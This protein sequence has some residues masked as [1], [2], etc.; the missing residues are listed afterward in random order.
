MKFFIIIS[1]LVTFRPLF[2]FASS[3][4]DSN[5]ADEFRSNF[6][7]EFD[8]PIPE[9]TSNDNGYLISN[10]DDGY[11]S[12]ASTSDSDDAAQDDE[13][14]V[15]AKWTLKS[16]KMVSPELFSEIKLRAAVM[17]IYGI[18]KDHNIYS[19][20]KDYI[21]IC[22]KSGYINFDP[23]S[24]YSAHMH[25]I[26]DEWEFD[27]GSLTFKHF[28]EYVFYLKMPIT[29]PLYDGKMLDSFHKKWHLQRKALLDFASVEIINIFNRIDPNQ[30]KKDLNLDKESED[31]NVVE[32]VINMLTSNVSE[33][34]SSAA[35]YER[36]FIQKIES[37]ICGITVDSCVQCNIE[38]QTVHVKIEE[39][40]MAK[41]LPV[42]D[43][44]YN[45][46][47]PQNIDQSADL[48]YSYFIF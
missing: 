47:D 29:S 45:Y 15:S 33:F 18:D 37:F 39:D 9:I 48:S 40:L 35:K 36:N 24:I 7:A 1:I 2:L 43:L 10:F 38:D 8:Y 22:C 46:N 34:L 21:D 28:C 42:L 26:F 13:F 20:A 14:K 5:F 16:L 41:I 19:T 12:L 32:M 6:E 31:T 3:E 11:Y 23:N 30:F 25:A 27:T 4:F 44:I 17:L